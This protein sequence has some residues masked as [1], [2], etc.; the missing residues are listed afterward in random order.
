MSGDLGQVFRLPLTTKVAARNAHAETP[1]H[2]GMRPSLG[3]DTN[4]FNQSANYAS[5]AISCRL[6]ATELLDE[7]RARIEWNECNSLI[8]FGL[9]SLARRLLT[10]RSNWQTAAWFSWDMRKTTP[11][12]SLSRREQT[13]LRWLIQGLRDKDIGPLLGLR[14]RSVTRIV[15][16]ICDKLNARTRTQAACIFLSEQKTRVDWEIENLAA[17]PSV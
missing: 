16:E 17:T 12:D 15:L 13:V 14:T 8:Q 4:R 6:A 3:D 9:S 1:L 7:S 2:Q 11:I 10:S 5:A